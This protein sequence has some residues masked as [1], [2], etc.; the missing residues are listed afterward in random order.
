MTIKPKLK[1]CSG[2]SLPKILWKSNPPTCK[3]CS[4]RE[5]QA[6]ANGEAP[7]ARKPIKT[8]PKASVNGM[9][10]YVA[11]YMACFGYG[12]SDFI[13]SELS[14]AAAIDVHHIQNRGSGGTKTEDRIENLIAVSREEHVEYGDKKQHMAFLYR[15]HRD[16]M[17]DN[18][19]KFNRE[20]IEGEIERW[21]LEE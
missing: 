6:K 8:K 18:G 19:V 14:N 11:L 4:G 9:Q 16:F 1:I 15:K 13:S 12:K 21:T 5:R 20:W 3:E 10:S 17:S 2:C 7:I